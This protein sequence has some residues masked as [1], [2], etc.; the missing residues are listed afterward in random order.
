MQPRDG[1]LERAAIL[2]GLS[3]QPHSPC[4]RRDWPVAIPLAAGGDCAPAAPVAPAEPVA[5]VPRRFYVR[6]VRSTVPVHAPPVVIAAETGFAGLREGACRLA[7]HPAGAAPSPPAAPVA[8]LVVASADLIPVA[9]PLRLPLPAARSG[10]DLE[11]LHR[12]AARLASVLAGTAPSP[13]PAPVA[14]PVMAGADAAPAAAPLQLPPLTTVLATALDEDP[15]RQRELAALL[16][17]ALAGTAPSLQPAPVARLVEASAIA[18]PVTASLQLPLLATAL[19]DDPERLRDVAALTASQPADA[20]PSLQPAPAARLVMANCALEAAVAASP[21][22]RLPR[23]GVA[24]QFEPPAAPVEAATRPPASTAWMASQPPAPAARIVFASMADS[25]GFAVAAPAMPRAVEPP[26]FG[27]A[28]RLPACASWRPAQQPVAALVDAVP[29]LASDPAGFIAVQLPGPAS[30][31]AGNSQREAHAG[32]AQAPAPQPVETWPAVEPCAPVPALSTPRLSV[33]VPTP[34]A[35]PGRARLTGSSE[36][37]VAPRPALPAPA[38]A[39]TAALSFG[40]EPSQLRVSAGGPVLELAGTPAATLHPA[41]FAVLDFHCRPKPGLATKWLRWIVP[42]IAVARPRL[43]VRPLF[44][45]W[46]DL[47]PA[48]QSKSGFDKIVE[49]RHAVRQIAASKRTR[50]TV[51]SVAAGLFLGTSLWLGTTSRQRLRENTPDMAI[52]ES[53]A[54]AAPARSA[55]PGAI[56]RLRQAISDRAAASWSDT[57]RGGMEA[58]GAGA[59]SWAP[60][61][62]R[63]ADG[64][65]QPGSLAIFHPTVN[66]RDYKLEFFGQIERKSM[67][68]V[69]RARDAQNY[70][71]MKFTVVEPG[72]RPFIA[73]VHYAVVGGK[74]SHYSQTPLSVMVHN[75]RPM[76]VLVDVKGDRFTAS[77][78][79]QEVG[80]WSDGTLSSGGVGFFAETGEK[81]RLYWM[82]VSKN[83]DILGRI[84][85]YIS[86]SPGRQSAELWPREPDSRPHRDGP[87]AP[88][89]PAEALSL[90]T[91]VT[92]RRSGMRHPHSAPR[93]NFTERRIE[94][95]RS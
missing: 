32:P 54:T 92:L 14:R 68:W 84:C 25:T 66:Y 23:F 12:L 27:A 90:A 8:S 89:E 61:W 52:N 6:P 4:I 5:A 51:G 60:G 95:W 35:I 88:F 49:M 1:N 24:A 74:K 82:R 48:G 62:Q 43:A 67:D 87:D 81:A 53:P 18:E 79:G 11:R 50:H 15:E 29:S 91:V 47:A 19:D 17:S 73:M 77:V 63:S 13:Q 56:S 93:A 16:A 76:Q 28:P 34:V 2:E 37:D 86:G 94:T 55:P 3:T 70:Y 30:W 26:Q 9:A 64:Y 59:K 46:E 33:P 41:P 75:G 42:A 21:A 22:S 44:D 83:E 10:E 65:V 36:P 78:D 58:W 80:S 72:L 85:A 31:R 39:Q 20:A 57:F 71:A 7:S 40:K 45:R 38:A 69:V